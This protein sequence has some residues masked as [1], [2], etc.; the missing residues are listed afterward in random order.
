V[1]LMEECVLRRERRH[2]LSGLAVEV[3]G[4]GLLIARTIVAA[5]GTPTLQICRGEM[6]PEF[7]TRFALLR[8]SVLQR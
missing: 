1:L 8:T 7:V 4:D 2:I 5:A 3:I 6:K